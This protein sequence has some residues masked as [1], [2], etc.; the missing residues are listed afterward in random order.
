MAIQ[1]INPVQPAQQ[2]QVSRGGKLGGPL[3]KLG[4]LIGGV[5]GGLAGFAAGGPGG[6]ALGAAKGAAFGA[7][8]GAG[9][10]MTLGGLIDPART[11]TVT[12]GPQTMGSVG[13]GAASLA[14]KYKLSDA[15]R[16][17]LQGL[18]VAKAN[19]QYEAYQEPLA[20]AIL[21]DIAAN[22]RQRMA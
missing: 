15:G 12:S 19:P 18:E 11:K 4:A 20:M 10:G 5:G 3:G 17:A 22:N 6:A 13:G 7:A 9:A 2:R 1:G 21:Q 8:Q 16:L 14:Q